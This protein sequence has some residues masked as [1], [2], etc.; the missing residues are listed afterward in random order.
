MDFEEIHRLGLLGYDEKTET[1]YVQARESHRLVLTR[2]SLARLVQM[3]NSIHTGNTL[4]LLPE[5]E[6]RRLEES[7]QRHS[8]A[9]REAHLKLDRQRRRNPLILLG[10]LLRRAFAT[11]PRS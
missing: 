5:Q 3:Y 10:R 1:W 6:L 8:E 11:G 4:V 2:R 9:L 7:R